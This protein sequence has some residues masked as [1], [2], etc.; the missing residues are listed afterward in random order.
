M[1]DQIMADVNADVCGADRTGPMCCCGWR[2]GCGWFITKVDEDEM[3]RNE[4]LICFMSSV[5]VF[6]SQHFLSERQEYLSDNSL[7]PKSYLRY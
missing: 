7:F 1:M 5:L 4:P 6:G 2:G 3:N